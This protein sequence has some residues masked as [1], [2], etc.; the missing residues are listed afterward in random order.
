MKIGEILQLFKDMPTKPLII[1]VIFFVYVVVVFTVSQ[2]I[3][4][5]TG[6]MK[7]ENEKE[8]IAKKKY[9]GLDI[10]SVIAVISSL[11]VLFFVKV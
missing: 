5:E 2:D 3:E 4:Q 6:E 9:K 11:C 8:K 10:F 1:L 7:D